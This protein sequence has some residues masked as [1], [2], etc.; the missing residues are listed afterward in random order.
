M[1]L[2]QTFSRALVRSSL[3]QERGGP[4]RGAECWPLRCAAATAAAAA[5]RSKGR[6]EG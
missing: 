6:E 4:P 5:G 1:R 2:F 3:V